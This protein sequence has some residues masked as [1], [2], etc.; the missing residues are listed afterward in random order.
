MYPSCRKI[1]D[2]KSDTKEVTVPGTKRYRI[3]SGEAPET[4]PQEDPGGALELQFR[5]SC[6]GRNLGEVFD[7]LV[8]SLAEAESR[9]ADPL[10]V[11][12]DLGALAGSITSLMKGLSHLLVGYPRTVTFWESSGFAEA[13]LSA[14]EPRQGSS[15]DP[16]CPLRGESE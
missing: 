10:I 7:E 5:I 3:P 8:R 6:K 4:N 13:F 16:D 2:K 9:S 15:P 14:M 11:L 1:V 12:E